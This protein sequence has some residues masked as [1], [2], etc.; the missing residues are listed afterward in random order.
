NT[1][2]ALIGVLA[3]TMVLL[4][5][6]GVQKSSYLAAGI[7]VACGLI[8]WRIHRLRGGGAAQSPIEAETEPEPAHE[9]VGLLWFGLVVLSG[10]G[11]LAL[12]MLYNRMFTLVFHN[13]VYTFGLVLAVFL[14]ALALGA[15]LAPRLIRRFGVELVVAWACMAGGAAVALSMLL[16]GL[17]TGLEEFQ[18]GQSFSGHMAAVLGLVVLIVALPVTILGVLL[19]AAWHGAQPR[20]GGG[21]RTVG[22]LTAAN[23]IAATVGSLAT[24]FVL[25]P[26]LGLW[27]SMLFAANL[28][29]LVGAFLSLRWRQ[30]AA[31]AT[32]GF[33]LWSF[34]GPGLVVVSRYQDMIPEGSQATVVRHWETPYGWIDVLFEPEKDWLALRENLHYVHGDTAG[35]LNREVRQG[36]LPLLLH[37]QPSD[38]LFLGLGTGLTAG[39][40]VLHPEVQRLASVE[41]I[42]QVVE[43]ARLFRK[44]NN[45]LLG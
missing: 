41:L 42:P 28:F 35:S 23:T 15:A 40:A 8:A 14:G 43:A 21:G 2:G 24:A 33:L 16:F 6:V 1:I 26:V 44:A 17:V 20:R 22:L 27:L 18:V 45:D 3:A 30:R 25:M 31:V 37:G 32:M 29:Y 7:S 38:V 5:V 9:G 10:F 36:H 34:A 39:A 4:V 11:T 19:P 12:E 13:S